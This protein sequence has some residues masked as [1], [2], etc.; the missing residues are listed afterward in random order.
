MSGPVTNDLIATD[1]RRITRRAVERG[2]RI[3]IVAGAFGMVWVAGAMGIASTMFMEE[4]GASGVVI[5]LV[6]TIQQVAMFMQI[7][8]AFVADRLPARKPFWATC[9][10]TQRMLWFIPAVLPFLF[11]GRNSVMIWGMLGVVAVSSLLAQTGTA[12]WF[13]WMADFVPERTRGRFWGVRQSMTM[14]AYLLAVAVTGWL[15]DRFPEPG[16]PGGSFVGFSLVFAL[17]ALAG[18]VDIVIHLWVPEPRPERSAVRLSLL[19]RALG[20]FKD[21]DFLWLTVAFG[22]W[23]FALGVVGSFGMIYLKRH[24][25]VEYSHLAAITI[26]ASLGAALSGIG[27]GRVLDMVGARAFGG[28]MLLITPLFG[29]VWFFVRDLSVTVSLPSLG[30]LSVPQPIFLLAIVNLFAGACYHGVALSHFSL[31][32]AV[33]PKEGRTIAMA[34]HW[35]CVGLLGALGP[36]L[37]GRVMDYVEVHPFSGALPTGTAISFFHVLV[38]I[39]V[40]VIWV[41]TLPLLMRVRKRTGDISVRLLIANPLRTVSVIQNILSV[42]ATATSRKRADAVRRIGEKGAVFAVSDLI[43]KLD[44]PAAEVR[45]EATVAL[46]RL[47]T[48]E[49]VDA[50]VR[51][52]E[53]PESDLGP[54][55]ARALRECKSAE[56]VDV[57]LRQLDSEDRET[58]A[59]SARTLGEIGDPR[60]RESLLGML[61][62]SND[63]KLVTASSEA[64]GRLGEMAA[65]YDILPRMKKTRNP[66]LQ[67][68][69]AVAVGDLLGGRERFYRLLMQE[70]ES[71]GSGVTRR[72]DNSLRKIR[73]A[74]GKQHPEL[75]RDVTR[76]AHDLE[77]AYERGRYDDAAALLHD[78]AHVLKRS[79]ASPVAG[80][81]DAERLT[82]GFWYVDLLHTYWPHEEFG[83]HDSIDILLGIHFLTSFM[84]AL[85]VPSKPFSRDATSRP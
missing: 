14:V 62:G 78:I 22:S 55:I 8:A 43:E 15:L 50:L 34:V 26:A 75:C 56:T 72:V 20:P 73:G 28:V 39:Q 35:T 2:L 44:D 21:P 37:G 52:L 41:V 42:S 10:M 16:T 7:P 76:R 81:Y 82:I 23:T 79:L 49:A 33:V 51:R 63:A 69:L 45:E 5:G 46:A 29:A 53:N 30:S 54:Q 70:Q 36:V 4:L 74:F 68:S 47:G 40:V 65:V 25:G 6:V 32:A 1:G 71:T 38:L 85:N 83:P 80:G 9:V 64:L 11:A 84:E 77:D 18:T 66:V 3:N 17:A 12:P 58:K 48:P 19:S 31:S 27:W 59:E 61:R 60:A 24:F 57:L 13:S 67:R